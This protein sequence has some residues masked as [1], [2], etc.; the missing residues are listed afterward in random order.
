LPGLHTAPDDP[1]WVLARCCWLPLLAAVLV[2]LTRA[3]HRTGSR[4]PG[5]GGAAG[6]SAEC[7]RSA[8]Q[9]YDDRRSGPPD[10]RR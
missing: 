6:R 8:A 10:F 9:V 5:G 4:Q 3:G 7:V 2:T 1:G